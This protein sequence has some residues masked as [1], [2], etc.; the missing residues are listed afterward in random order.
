M[1]NN[2]HCN[3]WRVYEACPYLNRRHHCALFPGVVPD[4]S[5][6]GVNAIETVR[7]PSTGRGIDIKLKFRGL[8]GRFTTEVQKKRYQ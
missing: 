3:R 6:I 8:I 5:G 4:S 7:L 2:T 1:V